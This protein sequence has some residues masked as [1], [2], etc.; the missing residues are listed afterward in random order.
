[1]TLDGTT[2]AGHHM[3]TAVVC[4]SKLRLIQLTDQ[5]FRAFVIERFGIV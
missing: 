2:L 5:K 3:K 1:M 4:G